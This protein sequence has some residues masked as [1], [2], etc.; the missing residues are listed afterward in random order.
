MEIKFF[1]QKPIFKA[2]YPISNNNNVTYLIQVISYID[3]NLETCQG[4]I[5]KT[6]TEELTKTVYE[7]IQDP[8]SRGIDGCLIFRQ[9]MLGLANI[10][11]ALTLYN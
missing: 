8:I 2:Y 9:A 3:I 7:D 1:L 6:L 4:S 10:T 5:N 11:Q